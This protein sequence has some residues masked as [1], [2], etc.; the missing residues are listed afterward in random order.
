MYC[1][2]NL[3]IANDIIFIYQSQKYIYGILINMP[4]NG[5][6]NIK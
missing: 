1:N 2:S 4:Q 6:C 5:I 3:N